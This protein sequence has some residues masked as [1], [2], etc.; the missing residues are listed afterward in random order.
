MD[1]PITDLMAEEA[2]Y[3][4]LVTWLHP[5]CLACPRRSADRIRVHRRHRAP[6]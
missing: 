5:Q 4:K 3:A 1:F 6:V 2:S